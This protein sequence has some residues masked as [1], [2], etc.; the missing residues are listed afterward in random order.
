MEHTLQGKANFKKKKN[1]SGLRNRNDRGEFV[2]ARTL[3]HNG[4]PP[5]HE[6]EAFYLLAAISWIAYMGLQNDIFEI[7]CK[8][9]YDGMHSTSFPNFE[10]GVILKKKN[11]KR[12]F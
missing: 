3:S 1:I 7:D 10:F 12:S 9:L 2:L 6:V 8:Q 4:N 11:V 5:V